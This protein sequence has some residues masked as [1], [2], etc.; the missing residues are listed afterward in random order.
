MAQFVCSEVLL[1]T[2]QSSWNT[3]ILHKNKCH[4][5]KS[6]SILEQATERFKE[7]DR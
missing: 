6:K 4:R 5:Y 3:K 2:C 1:E 7:T